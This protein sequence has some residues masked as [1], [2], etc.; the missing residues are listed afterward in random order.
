MSCIIAE[1]ETFEDLIYLKNRV[2]PRSDIHDVGVQLISIMK[3]LHKSGVV[4]RDIRTPNALYSDGRVSLVDFGLARRVY[5][6][7]YRPDIDFAYL[8]DLLLHL[9][10]TSYTAKSK[11]KALA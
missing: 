8:G 11:K 5:E 10:C 7:I 1:G 9:H 3:Y 4:H 6:R 2:S